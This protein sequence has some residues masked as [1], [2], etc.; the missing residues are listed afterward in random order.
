[1]ELG[2][3][4]N[5]SVRCNQVAE[6]S[7]GSNGIAVWENRLFVGDSKNGTLSVYEIRDDHGT[8]FQDR[9]VRSDESTSPPCSTNCRFAKELGAAADNI[10]IIPTTGDLV[11]S[12]TAS[13]GFRQPSI[14]TNQS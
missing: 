5:Q 10:N 11:V 3:N 6:R 13:L 2:A 8:E 14:V 7:P 4:G 1:M 9:I 12:S